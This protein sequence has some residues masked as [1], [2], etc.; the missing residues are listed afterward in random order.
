M[1]N[2]L[3]TMR[4]I[5]KRL[6]ISV[7]SVSRALKD[8]PSIGLRTKMRVQALAKELGYELN[9]TAIS[10]KNGK[11]SILGVILPNLTDG[12]FSS[13]ISGIEDCASKSNYTVLMGQSYDDI[14]KE[15]SLVDAMKSHRVDGV[16][17]SIAKHTTNYAHFESFKKY[18]I[19]V[20]FF[21]RI[22]NISNIHYVA[23]NLFTGTIAAINY[24]FEKGHRVIGMINGPEK[25][26]ASKERKEGYIE[27]MTKSR[28]KFDPSLIINTDLSSEGVYQAAKELLNSKRKPTGIIT[29]NDYVAMD[30]ITYARSQ[31]LRINKDVCFVSYANEPWN[32]YTVYPPMASVEQF[33]YLQGQKATEILMELIGNKGA[34]DGGFKKVIL[35]S[36]LVIKKPQSKGR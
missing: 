6:N 21:D 29:F 34:A 4:E 19:P 22:P 5:A 23:C 8:H 18:N 20:V 27:A 28:L 26:I 33:P 3:V 12:F 24:L 31:K 25:L 10:F 30:A 17:I 9:V 2:T 35:D 15:K 11:T 7:S 16:L 1:E 13:A 36:Q 32:N 14:D